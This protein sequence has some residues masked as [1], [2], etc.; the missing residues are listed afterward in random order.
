ML[1]FVLTEFFYFCDNAVEVMSIRELQTEQAQL[2][3]T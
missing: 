3:K 2:V 1:R